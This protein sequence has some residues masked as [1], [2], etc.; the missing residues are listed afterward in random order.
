MEENYYL[1]KVELTKIKPIIWRRILISD[2]TS[3]YQLHHIIQIS[4]GWLNYHLYYFKLDQKQWGNID[5]WENDEP[6]FKISNDRLIKVKDILNEDR[7]ILNYLYDMGDSW[8]HSIKL[9]K[10]IKKDSAIE[11]PV[12]LDGERSSPPE[13][14]GGMPGFYDLIETLKKPRS[15]EYKE[16]LEWLGYKYDPE[17]FEVEKINKNL[18]NLKKYI[19]E[20]EE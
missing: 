12:C 10:I 4:F 5:L 15:R 19:K 17:L 1:L 20:Y 3:L 9:E 6:D 2:N 16:I 8:S 11:V 14:C 7:P 13:D 18:K